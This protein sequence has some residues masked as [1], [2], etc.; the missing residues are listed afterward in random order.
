MIDSALVADAALINSAA[1][2]AIENSLESFIPTRV[3]SLIEYPLL[4]GHIT[5][6]NSE[7]H[8]DPRARR[9]PDEWATDVH[10]ERYPKSGSWQAEKKPGSAGP[11][12]ASLIP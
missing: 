7:I 5:S 10:E 2:N 12:I 9:P 6:F 11:H 1:P 8:H 4:P 3:P